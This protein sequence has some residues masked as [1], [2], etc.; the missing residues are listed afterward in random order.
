M[1]SRCYLV[2]FED[3]TIQG[4]VDKVNQYAEDTA[5]K[6]RIKEMQIRQEVQGLTWIICVLF[7]RLA[8]WI[9]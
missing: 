6:V 3:E 2:E 5:D 7:E 9:P 8:P 1:I 4:A